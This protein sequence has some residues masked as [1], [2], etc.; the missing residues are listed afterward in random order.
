MNAGAILELI[1]I[2]EL[3]SLLRIRLRIGIRLAIKQQSQQTIR[4]GSRLNQ[5]ARFCIPKLDQI[6]LN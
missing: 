1:I 5:Q 4:L 6:E 2:S 3:I